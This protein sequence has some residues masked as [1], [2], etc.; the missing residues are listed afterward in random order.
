M[1]KTDGQRG[2][3]LGT[4]QCARKVKISGLFYDVVMASEREV[5]FTLQQAMKA[6][7]D[8][9]GIPYSFILTSTLDGVG[10]QD[11]APVALPRE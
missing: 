9:T 10:G 4:Q 8:S 2:G 5:K 3:L 6:Q 11:H 7:R 1:S